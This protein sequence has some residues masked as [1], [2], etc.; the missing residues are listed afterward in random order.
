MKIAIIQ[1][2]RLGDILQTLPAI[3]GLKTRFPGCEISLIVRS[4]FADAAKLSRYVDEIIELPTA[5]ILA[6]ILS[7]PN[8][9]GKAAALK[10]LESWISGR[11]DGR[12]WD[13]LVNL[14]FSDVSSFIASI[15][16]AKKRFGAYRAPDGAYAM[17]D[18]WSRWFYSQVLEKNF[19]ILHLNDLFARICGVHEGIWPVRLIEAPVDV[20]AKTDGR[21]RIAIQVSASNEEK[22]PNTDA[23]IKI[24]KDLAAGP[25]EFAFFGSAKDVEK[26]EAVIKGAGVKSKS[27]VL[28]GRLTLA[29]NPAWLR[30]CDIAISP[31]T[32]LVHMASIVG[33]KCVYLPLG[34]VR[35]EET[36]PYGA[37][38][39]VIYPS[40][41]G[42]D[43]Y[44]E[45]ISDAVWTG[46]VDVAVPH[47]ITKM[48]PT[49]DG[50]SRSFIQPA[51]FD[52]DE[53]SNLMAQSLY[54][55]GE[56]RCS[57]RLEEIEIPQVGSSSQVQNLDR[58]TFA[59]D[60]LLSLRKAAEFGSHYC[61]KMIN[62]IE[63]DAALKDLS[64]K[65]TETDRLIDDLSAGVRLVKP[66][67]DFWRVEKANATG[68]TLDALIGR[69]E[70]AY[71]EL[72]QNVDIVVQLMESSVKTAHERLTAGR[73]VEVKEQAKVP[74]KESEV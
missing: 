38:H 23:W 37:G 24:I 74:M 72:Q 27:T 57:G 44:V 69:T 48:V 9:E 60:A 33:V 30:S 6:P 32:M 31:D 2:A 41:T 7:E 50:G 11:F 28:A 59:H 46:T 18:A 66:L 25:A 67:V 34:G 16:P 70:G 62:S 51:N 1:L 20:K 52:P 54:L 19:N 13:A 42:I 5:S 14:S 12:E 8:A 29:Q 36:G 10:E 56:F 17:D 40:G 73:K 22:S 63:D 61:V 58:V 71:R 35:P 3:Q 4:T 49:A 39:H 43:L 53:A 47:G 64:L 65:L 26:I 45:A 55:L 15:I 68:R 21:K